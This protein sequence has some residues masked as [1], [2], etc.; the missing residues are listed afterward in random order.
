MKLRK[1]LLEGITRFLSLIPAQTRARGSDYHS[2]GRVLDL[3]CVEPD[4]LFG[5]MVSGSQQYEVGL[6]FAD[7]IW[8]TNCT[9]PMQY[10]CKHVVAALLELQKRALGI[11]YSK[12]TAKAKSKTERG[13]PQSS[14]PSL[15]DRLVESLERK[16]G[17]SESV[18]IG[19]IHVLF[20]ANPAVIGGSGDALR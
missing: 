7:N 4:H 20:V 17:H 8:V 15:R 3:E 2:Q 11:D 12:S 13:V 18:F 6:A 19:K 1:D 10:D 14:S 16:L 9:C 5:A